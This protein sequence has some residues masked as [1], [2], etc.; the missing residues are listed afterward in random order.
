MN[1]QESGLSLSR[2]SPSCGFYSRLACRR[3]QN[4]SWSSAPQLP[5]SSKHARLRLP[6]CLRLASMTTGIPCGCVKPSSR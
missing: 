6:G 5:V 2:F 4:S 1:L 3:H